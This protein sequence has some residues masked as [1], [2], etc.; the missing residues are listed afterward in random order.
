MAAIDRFNNARSG[1]PALRARFNEAEQAVVRAAQAMKRGEGDAAMLA[2]TYDRTQ[3]AVASASRALERQQSTA[4]AN[5]RALEQMGV[6]VQRAATHQARLRAEVEKTNAVVDRHARALERREGR[7]AAMG[8][9]AGAAGIMAG[10]ELKRG[11]REVLS[12]YREFDKERRFGKA[13]MG[14]S[15]DAQAPLVAQ[16][17]HLGATT[18]FNDIQVLESQR[19]LAARGLKRDQVMG[20]IAPAASLGMALDQQLP[21]AV[22]GMEA[23]IFGFKKDMTSLAAATA[24]ARQTAD[25]QVKAAKISGMTPEDLRQLYKFGATPARM[26]GLSEASLLGFGGILKK[27]NIGGDEA[28]VA[29]RALVSTLQSPT[30][31][32]KTALLANG[33]NFRNYQ[34]T[35]DHLEVDPFV[36]DVAARYG[37]NLNNKTRAGLAGIFADKDMIAD[38]AKF[39]PAVTA[40][41]RGT[42]G[43]R[44]AKSLKSIA[45]AANRYRD[46]SVNSI[47]ANAFLRDLLTVLPG[48]LPLAN[49]LFGSKQGGR[50]ATALADGATLRHII[51][52]IENGSEGYADKIAQERMAGFDGAVSR[53]EGAVKN[54]ETAVGR[55]FD[56][57]GKGGMLTGAADWVARAIQRAAEANPKLIAGSAVAAGV[58]GAA[59][60]L[61]GGY[62]LVRSL[63]GGFGLSASAVALDGA[64]AALTAAAGVMGGK[65]IA[66]DLA[67]K[68]GAGKT[69]A[70]A[71]GGSVFSKA[72]GAGALALPYLGPAAVGA[73]AYFGAEYLNDASGITRESTRERHRR[74]AAKYNWYGKYIGD[75]DASL[76]GPEKGTTPVSGDVHGQ[77]E[78]TVK[79]DGG[80]FIQSVA[81]AV[82]KLT[83]TISSNGP[84]SAGLSSPDAGAASA[85]LAGP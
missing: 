36:A 7:R 64:A 5:K 55:S 63:A 9:I 78:V 28:G 33:L 59:A 65:G 4:L 47:D 40:L 56:N 8:Y 26:V 25:Y 51:G 85:G 42:L 30:A 29:F 6:D 67:G 72:W 45:G 48:N 43:G 19:E 15:N 79:L 38:P 52:E 82:M 74:Q 84:G 20:L 10:H 70:A 35:K 62:A 39:A 53:F 80:S 3:A 61:Y 49:K 71:A 32:A 81:R 75:H 69:A 37:V 1:I 57:D 68:V 34:R 12:T 22:R 58:G 54:L 50:I 27:A 17:I 46:S 73:G 14:I 16:A 2:R 18:K 31:G 83:G 76:L 13:V 23:A 66:G 77:A 21:E 41:L 11:T 44:D 60:T 24:S